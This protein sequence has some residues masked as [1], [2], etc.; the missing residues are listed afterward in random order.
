MKLNSLQD[1]FVEQVADLRSAEEQLVQ[2]LPK[3]AS[4]AS[5]PELKEAFEHH[6]VQTRNHVQRIEEVVANVGID[7][8]TETCKAMQGLIKEGEDIIS[9]PGDPAAKDA[10][11]IAA[12]QRVE[13]Y[14][15]AAYGTAKT[16]AGELGFDD[17]KDILDETLEE[18]SDADKLLTKIATGGVFAAGINQDAKV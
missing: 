4:A 15:I 3:M 17:A 14:E 5:S 18:E 9:A 7:V 2:A 13:H 6:L 1:V 12:A 11:L 16:I 8:P 10:A